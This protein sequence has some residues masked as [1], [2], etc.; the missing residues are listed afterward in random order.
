MKLQTKFQNKD[1]EKGEVV[2]ADIFYDGD[3]KFKLVACTL[4][5]GRHYFYYWSLKKLNEDWEDYEE[6]KPKEFWYINAMGLLFPGVDLIEECVEEIK[7][8]GN[9]FET[10]EEA[11]KV[12]EKLKAW[13]R[14]KDKGFE[15][16]GWYGGSRIIHFRIDSLDKEGDCLPHFIDDDTANDLDL[17]FGG[18][19]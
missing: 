6:P 8:I 5:G 15:F 11:E 18:K 2:E 14:L 16:E 12:V 10:K 9:Y 19:E 1:F 3:D 4:K 13:K 7:K 17:L